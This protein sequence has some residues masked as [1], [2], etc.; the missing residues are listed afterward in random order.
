MCRSEHHLVVA[1]HG[2]RAGCQGVRRANA[3]FPDKHQAL[4]AAS[5]VRKGPTQSFLGQPTM[6]AT[7]DTQTVQAPDYATEDNL[8]KS[9]AKTHS[10]P[11]SITRRLRHLPPRLSTA[12]GKPKLLALGFSP[13]KANWFLVS[14]R[15]SCLGWK[16]IEYTEGK[17]SF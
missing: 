7:S 11:S 9:P 8:K 16:G 10:G 4:V 12:K 17:S 14:L 2:H 13:R 3:A 1:N 5:Y 15:K 6:S